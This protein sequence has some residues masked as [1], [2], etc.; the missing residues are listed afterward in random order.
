[1]AEQPDGEIRFL[2][3]LQRLELRPGDVLVLK[4]ADKLS[5]ATLRNIG[6]RMRKICPEHKLIILDAGMELGVLSPTP[7]ETSE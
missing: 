1:M 3:D 4:T 7:A 6:E 2:G 5:L